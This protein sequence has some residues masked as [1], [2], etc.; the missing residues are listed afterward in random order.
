MQ[1]CCKACWSL[2]FGFGM[3]CTC[4][5]DRNYSQVS[6]W[7]S[8]PGEAWP[9]AASP[10]ALGIHSCIATNCSRVCEPLALAGNF[11][12]NLNL[13]VS[14][15]NGWSMWWTVFCLGTGFKLQNIRT[16]QWWT[17]TKL[18]NHNGSDRY[19]FVMSGDIW[20]LEIKDAKK[21]SLQPLISFGQA[22]SHTPQR[23]RVMG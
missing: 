14:Q 21:L 22:A 19:G 6:G 1:K 18:T 16:H 7:V 11:L 8:A 9:A 23:L 5:R 13:R 20:W 10:W 3:A 15:P 17:S 12:F 4:T 2:S